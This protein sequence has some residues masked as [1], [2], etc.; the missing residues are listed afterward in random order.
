MRIAPQPDSVSTCQP[1]PPGC[2]N[3][4]GGSSA[5]FMS[6]M[7]LTAN[8]MGHESTTT[9]VGC[10]RMARGSSCEGG[11]RPSFSAGHLGDLVG[12]ASSTATPREG[13]SF[14]RCRG[15]AIGRGT[16]LS[17][18]DFW[19]VSKATGWRRCGDSS[20]RP[21]CA[22][23][24]RSASAGSASTSRRRPSQSRTSARSLVGASSRASRS[25]PPD[26]ERSRSTP[27]HSRR[28]GPGAQRRPRSAC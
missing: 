26:T 21:A 12:C 20:R 5:Q 16:P 1:S 6:D 25:L 24:R 13:P 15:E 8:L 2:N 10:D 11:K 9:T 17:C 18:S 28:S 4:T 3:R 22:A 14:H 23:A 19:R 7:N 27:A